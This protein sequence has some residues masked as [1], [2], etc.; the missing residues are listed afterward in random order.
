MP[1]G[2]INPDSIT[3]PRGDKNLCSVC[4]NFDGCP[5]LSTLIPRCKAWHGDISERIRS[6][7]K[8]L[9]SPSLPVSE[10]FIVI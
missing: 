7:M 8:L 2:G 9:E 10:S 5:V 1:H 3:L 4:R 6:V